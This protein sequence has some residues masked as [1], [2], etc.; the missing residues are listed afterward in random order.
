MHRPG[1]R[2]DQGQGVGSQ[3]HFTGRFGAVEQPQLSPEDRHASPELGGDAVLG[4]LERPHAPLE[5]LVA[6]DNAVNQ[7]VMKRLL[8]KR[9]HRVTFVSDGRSAIAAVF[10]ERF[11]VVFMDVQMPELD[12]LEATRQIRQA[13]T[14]GRRVPIVA[15]T[16]HPMQGDKQRCLEAADVQGASA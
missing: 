15:H 4:L 11:D 1:Q 9:G 6:E 2:G 3:F 5:I 16:A 8:Q 13:E 14:D 7:L 12:G 10:R